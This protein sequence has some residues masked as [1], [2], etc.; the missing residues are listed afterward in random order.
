VNA[1]YDRGWGSREA[2]A[3]APDNLPACESFIGRSAE[4]ERNHDHCVVRTARTN[5]RVETRSRFDRL[6]DR[7]G[8]VPS[9]RRKSPIS[10]KFVPDFLCG[11]D[12]VSA[13]PGYVLIACDAPRPSWTRRAP[14]ALGS[15][16]GRRAPTCIRHRV[17]PFTAHWRHL[18]LRVRVFPSGLS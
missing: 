3:K 14:C 15:C 4:E 2:V 1:I 16:T 8:I 10:S 17:L 11:S 13:G 12:F 6:E 5:K 18:G 7:C 9:P